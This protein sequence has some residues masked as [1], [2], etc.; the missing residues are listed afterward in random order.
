MQAL[1]KLTLVRV[2]TLLVFLSIF[3]FSRIVD[4]I[5]LGFFIVV[6]FESYSQVDM[7]LP[8]VFFYKIELHPF[9]YNYF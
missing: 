7:M 1:R 6:K 9:L 5:Y 8:N 2:V 3:I 4:A